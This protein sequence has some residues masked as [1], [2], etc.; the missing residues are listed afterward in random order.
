[1]TFFGNIVYLH[2]YRVISTND[3]TRVQINNVPEKSHVVLKEQER[4]IYSCHFHYY[5]YTRPNDLKNASF[6][7]AS[8]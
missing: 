1:M 4:D 7:N 3:T 2:L 8:E 5:Q 6:N